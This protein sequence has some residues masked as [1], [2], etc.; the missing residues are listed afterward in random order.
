MEAAQFGLVLAN[1]LELGPEVVQ[2]EGAGD[3]EDV[4]LACVV[5][6]D[7]AAL[8]WLHDRLKERSENGGR[9]GRPVEPGA[10]Q[11]R[12]A[13]VPVEVGDVEVVLTEKFSVDV[14][15][16]GQRLVEVL[17]ALVFRSV[18]HAEQMGEVLAEVGAILGGAIF[19]IEL[20]GV[21]LEE[22]GVLREEAE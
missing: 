20:E 6:A 9:D 5:A 14:R 15:E 8:A 16:R 18:Q 22:A 1:A 11:Q 7:L 10:G 21:A 12:V 3:F 17:L 19:K 2:E 13:H 4:A